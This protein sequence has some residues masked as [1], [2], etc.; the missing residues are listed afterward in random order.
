MDD[1]G[2]ML[3]LAVEEPSTSRKSKVTG[4]RWKDRHMAKKA[5]Q[6]R[7]ERAH[8]ELKKPQAQKAKRPEKRKRSEVEKP[9]GGEA[10]RQSQKPKMDSRG[11]AFQNSRE[12]VDKDTF[13]SS[14]FSSNPETTKS[15]AAESGDSMPAVPHEASNAPLQDAT[16]FDGLGLNSKLTD[17]LVSKMKMTRPTKIQRACLPRLI[18]RDRDLFVQAQTGSG[19]TLSYVLPILHRLMEQPD[20]HRESGLFALILAPTRELS[21]QIYS[22]LESLTR[23]CH[24]LVP[25]IVIGGE[26]KKAEKARIRKGINILVATP[27]RLADHF[28]NTESLDLS[29][30]RWLVLDEGDR[31]MELGF[32]ETI[33]KILNKIE[34]ESQIRTSPYKK[35]PRR[36]VNVLC[37]ATMKGDVE[38]L[39][40]LSL[41]DADWASTDSIQDETEDDIKASR[42]QVDYSAPAQ[43]LQECSV[44]PAKLRLVALA[45]V[46]LDLVKNNPDGRIMVFFSCSDSVDFHFAAFTREGQDCD[47]KPG[48][49][50]DGN[51]SSSTVR[52]SPLL[53]DGAIVYKLHGSLNQQVRTSTLAAFSNK[54]N[55]NKVAG[56]PSI[57]FCT[58]VASRGLDLPQ[59]SNVVEY[60]PPFAQEDHVHRVGRTARAGQAGSSIIFLLPGKEEGYLDILKSHH[61]NGINSVS[62]ETI[63]KRA[64]GKK[65]DV[66][67]TTWH[68]NVERWLLEDDQALVK[69]RHGFQSHIRAY[70]T[71]L[72]AE[73]GVFDM[74]S[75]HLGHIAKSFALRETPGGGAGKSK[76][77]KSKNN[78]KGASS[79]SKANGDMSEAESRRLMM[80]MAAKVVNTGADEFNIGY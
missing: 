74:K 28:D 6:K 33:T 2:M 47:K 51:M 40:Q 68:L 72:S 70:T 21:N 46:L 32:E 37:S 59:I 50:E 41:K 69:A 30:I 24:W 11:G 53:G 56:K 10:P 22:V 29:E 8:P 44:V 14:L 27:G 73:R 16:T 66:D 23:S 77:T 35:L 1:D 75:L 4:G 80:K 62:Y 79:S 65:W 18:H 5:A 52:T 55:K 38:K 67:A 9:E 7:L 42:E 60:D 17:H 12:G 45:G 15:I 78:A 31:L 36:R 3:N 64:F 43:L 39:G 19:K 58:D 34:S 76:K 61:P 20:L 13:V 63:L 49:D 25:G 54:G 71:H 26:K 48:D 57:L